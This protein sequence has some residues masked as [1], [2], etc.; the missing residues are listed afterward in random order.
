MGWYPFKNV[1]EAVQKGAE[2]RRDAKAE[3]I[4]EKQETKLKKAQIKADVRVEK[5][6]N[7][8]NANIAAYANGIDPKAAMWG[9]IAS[10]G[11]S[12]A[13]GLTGGLSNM[14]GGKQPSVYGAGVGGSFDIGGNP[15][16]IYVV[17]GVI[18]LVL[19]TKK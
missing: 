11:N 17:I 18:A 19:L 6:E 3:R 5:S 16:I 14:G 10:L 7:K 1:I 8:A 13:A 12:A 9:G 15:M 2:S 4:D